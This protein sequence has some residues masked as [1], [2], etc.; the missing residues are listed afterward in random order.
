MLAQL[1]QF[2]DLI[3][4]VVGLV[5]AIASFAVN[6]S[7]VSGESPL[8]GQRN[9][10]AQELMAARSE[11]STMQFALAGI[12]A[13]NVICVADPPPYDCTQEIPRRSAVDH[14]ENSIEVGSLIAIQDVDDITA[15]APAQLEGRLD[16]AIANYL[17]SGIRAV[18][19][20]DA[21]SALRD[22]TYFG[23]ETDFAYAR[24]VQAVTVREDMLRDL[25]Q[26]LQSGPDVIEKPDALS[27]WVLRGGIFLGGVLLGVGC[28]VASRRVRFV[29]PARLRH[30]PPGAD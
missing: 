14:A 1:K 13:N 11:L 12:L 30:G 8:I 20:D 7:Q 4:V 28:V 17:R 26:R 3:A 27:L 10:A 29:N 5:I 2:A 18:A 22:S 15:E 6:E 24:A 21:L 23:T 19:A 16:L 9:M 25:E